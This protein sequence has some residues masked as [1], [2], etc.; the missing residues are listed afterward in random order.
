MPGYFSRLGAMRVSDLH[1]KVGC[2]PTYRKD[3]ILQ[4]IKGDPLT[5]PVA[6]ALIFSLLSDK[7]IVL[8]RG[9]TDCSTVP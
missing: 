6:E 9:K 2:L 8:L 5:P 7:E 1:L 3:G 4:P